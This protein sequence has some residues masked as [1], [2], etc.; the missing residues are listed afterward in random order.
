[1]SNGIPFSLPRFYGSLPVTGSLGA[2]VA[3]LQLLRQLE[4]APWQ[5]LYCTDSVLL[6]RGVVL[7]SRGRGG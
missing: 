6:I 4:S 3:V 2:T 1:M 5:L 7:C